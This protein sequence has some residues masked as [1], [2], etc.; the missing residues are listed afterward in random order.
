VDD[1]A[2]HAWRRAQ[3]PDAVHV[4]RRGAEVVQPGFSIFSFLPVNVSA[5]L[6][7]AV[8]RAFGY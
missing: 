6:P 4:I 1:L 2:D 8:I 5:R 7:D 3:L